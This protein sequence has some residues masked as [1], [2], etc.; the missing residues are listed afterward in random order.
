MFDGHGGQEAA[1][2]AAVHFHANLGAHE[3]CGI[4]NEQALKA[5]Y[6]KTDQ[7]FCQHAKKRVGYL[8]P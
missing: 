3:L 7:L 6:A 5:A 2:Y 8:L 1:D 4:N